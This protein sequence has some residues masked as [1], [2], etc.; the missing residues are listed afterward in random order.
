MFNHKE[1]DFYKAVGVEPYVARD[2]FVE[3]VTMLST[4]GLTVGDKMRKLEE[5]PTVVLGVLVEKMYNILA[6]LMDAKIREIQVPTSGM[7][8]FYTLMTRVMVF[9]T[10]SQIVEWLCTSWTKESLAALLLSLFELGSELITDLPS[11]VVN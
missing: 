9:K 2:A 10:R 1:E 3:V 5:R 7:C 11:H 8:F 6:K 4:K